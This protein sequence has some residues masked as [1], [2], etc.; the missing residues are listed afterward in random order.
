MLADSLKLFGA[1]MLCMTLIACGGSGGSSGNGSSSGGVLLPPVDIADA[2]V[3]DKVADVDA[4]RM[5][6]PCKAL[7]QT[8]QGEFSHRE[9]CGFGIALHPC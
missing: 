7:R 3:N 9:R 1:V 8:T 5:Q 4:L 6:F 2:T